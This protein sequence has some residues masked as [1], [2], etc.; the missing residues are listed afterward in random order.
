MPRIDAG[1]VRRGG[2]WRFSKPS[3]ILLVAV[4]PSSVIQKNTLD[5]GNSNTRRCKVLDL[6]GDELARQ[7]GWE[8]VIT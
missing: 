5:D 8:R 4:E 2:T 6:I 1:Q 3:D 7:V